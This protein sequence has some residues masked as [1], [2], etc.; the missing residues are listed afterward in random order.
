MLL[1]ARRK[2]LERAEFVLSALGGGV[3]I[4]DITSTLSK[5]GFVVSGVD[6]T[7]SGRLISV[8]LDGVCVA[9]YR[10]A[11]T[12]SYFNEKGKLIGDHDAIPTYGKIVQNPKLEALLIEYF[13][14]PHRAV[15]HPEH[16]VWLPPQSSQFSRDLWRNVECRV[17]KIK[18]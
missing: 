14:V 17:R 12:A 2:A 11:I 4:N 7:F 18:K 1:R 13:T 15:L 16:Y 3:A 9:F 10:N 8:E 5:Y 6:I